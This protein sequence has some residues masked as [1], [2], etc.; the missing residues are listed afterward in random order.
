MAEPFLSEIRMMSFGFAPRGWALSNGQLL[1]INQNQ[2]LF[3]LLGTTFGGDGRVN[4][5]LPDMRARTPIHM[6]NGHTLGER[7]GEQSHTL[8]TS[9][10][11]AHNHLA[12]AISTANTGTNVVNPS[13]QFFATSTPATLYNSSGANLTPLAANTLS[14]VGGSQPHQNMQPYLTISFCIALQGIFPSQT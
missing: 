5:G 14:S 8:S 6:G 9:E 2:A 13:G 3:S 7:A 10:M 1:P 4:F 11:P 12:T